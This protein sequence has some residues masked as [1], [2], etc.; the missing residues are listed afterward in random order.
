VTAEFEIVDI[1]AHVLP[2]LDDG[3]AGLEDALRMCELYVRDGVTAVVATPHMGDHRFRVTPHKVRQAVS[4]LNRVCYER[5]LGLDVL[6][7]ADVRLCP[8][9]LDM[10]DAGDVLT[11]AD[12]GVYLLLEPPAGA[13]PP[14]GALVG[15][16]MSRGVTPVVSHPERHPEWWRRPQ[17]LR[18]L[19]ERG[20]V[21]Q[22]TGGSFLG[23]F[24]R[25]AREAAEQLVRSGLA[26]VVAGDT[27]AP[28]GRRRPEF[29][30]VL[31]RLVAIVGREGTRRLV[32][33]NPARIVRGAAVTMAPERGRRRPSSAPVSQRLELRRL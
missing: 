3:P 4:S 23:A 14:L 18:E 19:V 7:G 21:L 10:L 31:R 33:D 27:H 15:E 22:V 16:L 11:L 5:G 20:C 28:T 13:I 30:R 29:G 9:L 24:G 25:R 17:R 1:H 26:H 8:E 2:G 32:Q 12:A 6:P